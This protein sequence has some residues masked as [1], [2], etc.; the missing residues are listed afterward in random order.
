LWKRYLSPSRQGWALLLFAVAVAAILR[1]W[2]LGEIPP[3]LYRDEAFNG[4]DALRVLAG[5][6]ALFFPAN[7]G[8]E[9]AYIY[10]TALAVAGLGQTVLALRITAAVVGTFT[11]LI[12]YRLAD[13]W[14]GRPAG[15]LAAWLWAVTFW[16]VHLS[17]IGLR[18][19]LFVAALTLTFW[20]G[21]EA[22]R[23]QRPLWWA[24][25]G[26]AYAFCF[27]TYLAARFT[28]LLLLGLLLFLAAQPA[29][30]KR[31][32]PGVAWFGGAALIGVLP[33]ALALIQ[34]PGGLLGRSQQVSILNP[35]INGG[36]LW[37]TLW[38]QF[39][40]ALGL[41]IWRGDGIWRHNLPGRPA[42]DLLMALPFLIGMGF[43]LRYWRRPAMFVLPLWV[44]VML[45][46]T[47]LAED[48]PHFLRAAGVL[49]PLLI[50]SA[51]GLS[52]LRDW[53]TLPSV[54]QARW[55]PAS[56][57]QWR[58][59]VIVLLCLATLAL[60]LR[61]YFFI[62]GRQP[63]PALFFEAAARELAE[64][65]N[66]ES[67]ETAVYLDDRY[68]NGDSPAVEFLTAPDRQ[69]IVY[70]SPAGP[71][72]AQA[73][74][75]CDL[76]LTI[77]AWPYSSLDFIPQVAGSLAEISVQTGALARGDLETEAYPFYVRYHA[78]PV[79]IAPEPVANFGDALQLVTAI[80][81][82][83]TDDQMQLELLWTAGE[84]LER[85]LKVFVHLVDSEGRIVAQSDAFPAAGQWPT[86]WWQPGLYLREQH[87][88]ALSGPFDSDNYD[89]LVGVYDPVTGERLPA[90]DGS[91]ELI[92]DAWTLPLD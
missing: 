7:N 79:E 86:S 10:L 43:S 29:H 60:T 28:P 20:L 25:A 27:Y 24:A 74:S 38:R 55:S 36:D 46:P 91:G 17:R 52:K 15:L 35:A 53:P 84:S 32:W 11:T 34:E 69:P 83:V 88:L 51:L 16:A 4:L 22:Y 75:A 44:L 66:S 71:P 30:R 92:G 9:P 12:I 77:Y 80:V 67:A 18:A 78:V 54:L 13:S 63:E 64:Q 45:G 1:F 42:L 49:P 21:T 59:G 56:E 89:I 26:L 73:E 33:L 58:T 40:L 23:R 50:L 82:A 31:L 2:R 87:A 39:W 62:Y 6:H 68:W 85:P 90:L 57:R 8:R 47:I 76:P 70:E 37:G 3:G 81:E 41:T 48:A 65:I 19:V 5:E 72:C 61:D 14:F